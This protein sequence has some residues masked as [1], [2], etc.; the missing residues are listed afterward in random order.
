MF[1]TCNSFINVNHQ[2]I[3]K[4]NFSLPFF[5]KKKYFFCQDRAVQLSDGLNKGGWHKALDDA[6]GG[7]GGVVEGLH[8]GPAL[9]VRLQQVEVLT[10]H[11]AD[12]ALLLSLE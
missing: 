5:G 4:N 12:R 8:L 3:K 9:R 6:G 11:H 7:G 2:E 10:S 1:T